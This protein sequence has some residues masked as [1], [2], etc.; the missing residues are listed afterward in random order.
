VPATFLVSA[1]GT[2]VDR[3]EGV[4]SNESLARKLDKLLANRHASRER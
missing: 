4:I 3:I 1:D 2:M